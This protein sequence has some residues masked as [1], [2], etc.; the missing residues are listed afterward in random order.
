MPERLREHN[1]AVGWSESPFWKEH[2]YVV[3][4]K[5]MLVERFM[6]AVV[7]DKHE[8]VEAREQFEI[9]TSW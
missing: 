3:A 8:V 5:F 4:R 9:Q 6:V 1:E 7:V 2:K